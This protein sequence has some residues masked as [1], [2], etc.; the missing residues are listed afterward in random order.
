MEKCFNN[1]CV[2]CKEICC[3]TNGLILCH[4]CIHVASGDWKRRVVGAN[5]IKRVIG[6][7]KYIQLS[8]S[9]YG[10]ESSLNEQLSKLINNVLVNYRKLIHRYY[11]IKFDNVL[12]LIMSNV[13]LPEIKWFIIELIYDYRTL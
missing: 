7:E 12:L 6:D 11:R 4:K 8:K 10:G 13:L 1:K 2:V 3:D 9:E 5:F